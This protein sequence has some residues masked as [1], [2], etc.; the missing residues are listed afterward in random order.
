[1]FT[2]P[3]RKFASRTLIHGALV[4]ATLS[5]AGC[6]DDPGPGKL[7]DEDGVWELST[8]A[9]SGSGTESIANSRQG[10][11]LLMFDEANGFVQT[12]MCSDDDIDDPT[13]SEC[14]GI[15][16]SMWIC[17]CFGY[18]FVEDQMAWLQFEAGGTPP[19]VKVGEEPSAGGAA[20]GDGSGG[21]TD[22]DGGSEGGGGGDEGG[23]AEGGAHQFAVS[24]FAGADATFEFSPL[25]A[26]IFGSD[27]VSSK[28]TFVK[29]APSVFDRALEDP[30]R[31]PC[32]PC[33]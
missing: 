22:S 31:P 25:P 4:A 10:E 9:L 15:T 7:F 8:F 16:D 24:E 11:F 2:S 28:F 6:K 20:G 1:M 27:G 32:Q 17:S 3:L 26:G 19:V 5:T 14:E 12:A 13:D 21:D 18:D 33:I 29:K 23:Q 30:D